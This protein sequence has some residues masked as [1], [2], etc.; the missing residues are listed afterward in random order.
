MCYA[1][2]EKHTY[3][4][5]D[6]YTQLQK[7]LSNVTQLFDDKRQILAQFQEH[8]MRSVNATFDEAINDL[9]N[10]RR[11]SINYVKQQ[12]NDANV[13]FIKIKRIKLKI[14]SIFLGNYVRNVNKC[15][16]INC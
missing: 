4:L 2:F 9:E 1:C 13:S 16:T 10:L 5:I 3:Q 11:E 7:R 12:F 14:N 6:E 15:S 8:C